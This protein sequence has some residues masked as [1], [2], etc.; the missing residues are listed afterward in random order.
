MTSSK[1]RGTDTYPPQP[2]AETATPYAAPPPG[3][4]FKPVDPDLYL[5]KKPLAAG[6]M[7]RTFTAVD[8]R[9]GRR[10]VLKELPDPEEDIPSDVRDAL[11]LRLE[12]EARILA[13][14][15]HP[16]IVTVYEAG[17]WTDGEP[18]YAMSF[19]RGRELAEAVLPQVV[20]VLQ[21]GD[22]AGQGLAAAQEAGGPAGGGPGQGQTL[23]P[24][25]GGGMADGDAAAAAGADVGFHRRPGRVRGLSP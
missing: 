6:G 14:L 12:Q 15:Q 11:R 4:H 13:G 24:E 2:R 18:F 16:N 21:G 25:Q 5:R 3:A 8:L 9:L 10:V 17:V 20:A 23:A 1:S 22:V 19:V 7:G